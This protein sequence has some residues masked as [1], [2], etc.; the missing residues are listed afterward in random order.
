MTVVFD[1]GSTICWLPTIGCTTKQC[2]N[3][4]FDYNSSDSFFNTTDEGETAYVSGSIKGTY[5][6][7]HACVA[8][9]SCTK[10]NF[11]FLSVIEATG[12]LKLLKS[13]G[14]CGLAP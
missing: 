2:P 10:K 6:R 4:R 11:K 7:D 13:D 5:T 12:D 3:G 1:P 9:T 14:V 8:S